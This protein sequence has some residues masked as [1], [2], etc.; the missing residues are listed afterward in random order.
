[1]LARIAKL[2]STQFVWLVLITAVEAADPG[3]AIP[4]SSA[5]SDQKPGSILVYNFYSSNFNNQGREDTRISITNTNSAAGLA[6]TAFVHLFFLD[7]ATCGP[8]N[9]FLCLTPN[10]TASFLMSDIDPGTRGYIIAVAVDPATGCPVS[11]NFLIGDAYLKLA[12]GHTANLAAEAF[13]ALYTGVLPSCNSADLSATLLFD[14]TV[15]NRAPRVLAASSLPSQN[16][17]DGNSTFLI[18]NSIGG[19]LA[20]AAA[21]IGSLFGYLFDDV[22][23]AFSFT[24]NGVGCQLLR[25][26]ATE[27]P[28]TTPPFNRV[29]PAGHTGWMKLFVPPPNNGPAILGA[30]INANSLP[31]GIINCGRNLHHLTLAPSATLIIPVLPPVC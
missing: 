7:G 31:N 8:A 16:L 5:L 21:S 18:V 15:Y 4:A 24:I 11:F 27:P 14:D 19:D 26:L 6:G 20:T 3:V 23:N 28:R 30:V 22:E 17:V 9:A 13:A 1:M 29:I 10:Q 12:T 2:V 25:N